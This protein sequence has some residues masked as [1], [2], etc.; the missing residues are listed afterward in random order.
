MG[1]GKQE[2]KKNLQLLKDCTETLTSSRSGCIGA[3]SSASS[4]VVGIHIDKRPFVTSVREANVR[5]SF[6]IA[7]N[8]YGFLGAIYPGRLD[9]GDIWLAP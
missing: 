6:C 4:L 9:G 2:E 5:M 3:G 7:S 1:E 8:P